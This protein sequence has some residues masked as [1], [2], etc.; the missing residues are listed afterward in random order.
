VSTPR[1]AVSVGPYVGRFAPSPNGP[2][3]E[4]S[5]LAALASWHDASAHGGRWLVRMEDVDLSRCDRATGEWQLRQ[6][7]EF[8]LVSDEPVV[9]QSERGALYQAALDKLMA[10]GH[11]FPCGCS[12]SDVAATQ[13]PGPIPGN[14]GEPVYAG[15]CRPDRGGLKGKPLRAWRLRVPRPDDAWV[16]WV[17]RRLGPQR[18]NLATEH[19]DFVLWSSN[20]WAYQLAVVVDDAAQ[21]VTDVVRGDDL[22]ASTARQIYLQ[23]LLGLPTPRYL[24]IATLKASTGPHAGQKLSKQN[25]A[26]AVEFSGSTSKTLHHAALNAIAEPPVET[27]A[28]A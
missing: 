11:A 28:N 5:M 19:G 2:L 17:D 20:Q 4:G 10:D 21:G 14:R 22:L 27:G 6:L 3:H 15:T 9:W 13:A 12:R 24:H 26:G 16:E 23:R 25:G 7:A 18:Q 1:A 8:G